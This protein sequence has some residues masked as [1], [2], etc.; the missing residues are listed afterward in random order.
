MHP[1]YL[2]ATWVPASPVPRHSPWSVNRADA[3]LMSQLPLLRNRSGNGGSS[4]ASESG[5]SGG[6]HYGIA[7]NAIGS[8]AEVSYV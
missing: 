2:S 4:I 8:T 3:G 1:K 6:L 5:N 7:G